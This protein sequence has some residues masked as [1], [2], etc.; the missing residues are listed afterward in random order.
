MDQ[1]DSVTWTG[2]YTYTVGTDEKVDVEVIGRL[3]AVRFEDTANVEWEIQGYDLEQI[4][5]GRY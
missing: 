4:M 1:T 2:P 3:I 5:L